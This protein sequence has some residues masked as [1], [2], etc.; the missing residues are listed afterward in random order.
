MDFEKQIKLHTGEKKVISLEHPHDH[1]DICGDELNEAPY[2]ICY[3]TMC[4]K[5]FFEWLEQIGVRKE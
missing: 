2:Q 4:P 1:C 3:K 5:C